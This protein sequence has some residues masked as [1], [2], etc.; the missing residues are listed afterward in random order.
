MWY[1]TTF[2]GKLSFA[3]NITVKELTKIKTFLWEDCRDHPE[4]GTQQLTYIDLE[5]CEDL[6]WLIWDGSEKTYDLVDKVNL[7]ITEM[8]KEFPWFSLSGK[9]QAEWEEQWDTWTLEIQS[10][11]FAVK[12]DP[13][14]DITCPHC[15]QSFTIKM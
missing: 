15:A 4:W 3:D 10:N 1:C 14:I 9:L 6:S 12:V 7:I 13:T 2:K 11:W 8:R 5:L